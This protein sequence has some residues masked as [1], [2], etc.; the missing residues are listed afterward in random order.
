MNDKKNAEIK[1][2]GISI[3]WEPEQGTCF[4]ESL[5]VAMMWIDTT[6]AGL[7]SGVQAMVGT[8]RFA[9]ALQS[10]GRKSVAA[11][12]EV[13]SKFPDFA[14]GFAAIANIAAVAGW[15]QW[16]LISIDHDNRI[17]RFRVTGS[18]ES[19]YQTALG[20]CWGSAM[21]AGKF[22]GYA[23][24]LFGTNCWAD[25]TSYAAR[26]GEFDEFVVSPSK[27]KLE[28]E[29]DRL[30][31]SDKATRADMAVALEQLRKEMSERRRAEEERGH[32]Q[33]EL[34]Q[35]RK[36]ESIGRLAGGVAHDFNNMLSPILGYAELLLSDLPE[37]SAH[38]HRLEQII[39]AAKSA[40]DL[41]AQLLAF[42]RK[43][44]LE[45]RP[46]DL[47]RIIADFEHILRRTIR[48]NVHIEL[49]LNPPVCPIEA[50]PS[51]IEQI[52]LNLSINAQ[53]AMPDGGRLLIETSEVSLDEDSIR[54]DHE[55]TPGKYVVMA[56]RDTG[57][58]I[59]S[60]SLEMIFEPFFTT[61]ERGRGTGLGLSTVYGI[62][63]QHGGHISVSSETGG[64]TTF[65]V[66]FPRSEKEP[67]EVPITTFIA[68]AKSSSKTV[69]LVEDQEQVREFV[70]EIL[71]RQG[72]HVLEAGNGRKTLAIASS[73]RSA[74]DLL[75]TDVIMPDMDGRTL[76]KLMRATSPKLK[77]LFMSGYTADVIAHHGIL[78][79]GI[80]F[81]QKP[82]SVK[83]FANKVRLV[84]ES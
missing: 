65:R 76:Y 30:L 2:A 84:L 68:P 40:R 64:G 80:H 67:Q 12:W 29:I 14:Q 42:G 15:G 52:I 57:M 13:I 28:D 47:N 75:V 27:R 81:I 23:S 58:G 25:Q 38:H 24:R 51:Q 71:A 26:G 56:V 53:D 18:W 70:R 46:L 45:M 33:A 73:M 8:E 43:Q 19:R 17:C 59:E 55:A 37:N 44:T 36:L 39:K 62:V 32:L 79:D 41:T 63:K 83:D 34:V 11:D 5:P 20:V 72:Y 7:M 3:S 78:E 49:K 6:L 54:T 50:D 1:V 61:K 82:F 10:E 74:I 22:A 35:A 60:E 21:A 77:V 4:F 69:L 66:F 16:T 9:L 48:E 31:Q